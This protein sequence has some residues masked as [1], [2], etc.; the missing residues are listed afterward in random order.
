MTF[1]LLPR[2]CA[3]VALLLAAFSLPAA[4]EVKASK[5]SVKGASNLQTIRLDG[6]TLFAS[7]DDKLSAGGKKALDSA[8]KQLASR[9]AARYKITGHADRMGDRNANRELSARR[10]EAVRKYLLSRDGNLRLEA[11]GLGDSEPLVKCADA[12]A[13][14]ALVKCL[15][16]NRRVEIDPLFD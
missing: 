13:R 12:M 5:D 14:D 1:R 4:A 7:N 9:P 11:Y 3:T 2:H 16:P 15:A 8:L 10:A 6:S